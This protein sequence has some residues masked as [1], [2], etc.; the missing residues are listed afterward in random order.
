MSLRYMPTV[1][2]GNSDG[3]R[4]LERLSSCGALALHSRAPSHA[5]D[6]LAECNVVNPQKPVPPDFVIAQT[7]LPTPILGQR[8]SPGGPANFSYARKSRSLFTAAQKSR[9]D[10]A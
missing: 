8:P 10:L 7:V 3:G 2:S 1:H 6:A 4:D 9:A 5:G